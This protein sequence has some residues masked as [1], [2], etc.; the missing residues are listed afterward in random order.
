MSFTGRGTVGAFP[1]LIGIG[2]SMLLLFDGLPLEL[3]GATLFALV[4]ATAIS[5]EN[6]I[7]FLKV[8]GLFGCICLIWWYWRL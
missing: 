7:N 5:L 1:L 4:S 2:A 8:P 6:S 3:E